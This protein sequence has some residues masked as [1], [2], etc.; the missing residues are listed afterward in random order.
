MQ[1]TNSKGKSLNNLLEK[2]N[3]DG[4]KNIVIN[5][6]VAKQLKLKENERF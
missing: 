5:Q 3:D 1:L 4:T 2:N 6:T